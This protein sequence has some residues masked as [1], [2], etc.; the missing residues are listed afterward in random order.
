MTEAINRAAS[1]AST[2]TGNETEV[3]AVMIEA[4]NAFSPTMTPSSGESKT[5]VSVIITEV[6]SKGTTGVCQGNDWIEL[7]NAGTEA[8]DL[9][10]GYVLCDDKGVNDPDAFRF[11]TFAGSSLEPQAYLVLCTKLSSTNIDNAE[12][13]KIPDPSYPQFGI[14]DTDTLSLVKLSDSYLESPSRNSLAYAIL[15]KVGPLPGDENT[16][17]VTYA[18]DAESGAFYYTSTPTPAAANIISPLK[19]KQQLEE[20]R[21][22]ALAAQNQEGAVFFNF[23]NDGLPVKDGMDEMLQL[24]ISMEPEDYEWTSDHSFYEVYRPFQSAKVTDLKGNLIQAFDSPGRIRPKGQSSL[25]MARCLRTGTIPF[26]V[27]MDYTDP[28]Q[29]LFGVQRFYLRTHIADGSYMRDWAY[30]RML[31]RF[32]LPYLRARSVQLIINDKIVGPIYT[33]VE[34]P[35]QE[36]VFA[37]NFP[38]H[39]PDSFA[40]YKITNLGVT[41]GEYSEEQIR[42]ATARLYETN[43]PPYAFERGVHR[44]HVDQLGALQSGQCIDNYYRDVEGYDMEDVVLAWLRHNK[45]CAKM[46]LSEGLVD[47]DLGQSRWDDV[48]ED[49]LDRHLDVIKDRCNQGCT[50]SGLAQ[51]VDVDNFLKTMAFYAVTLNQDSP[52][53]NGN[54][55]YLAQT[56]DGKGWK[57]QA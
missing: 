12:L 33:L 46:R 47:R 39:K 38:D 40:L 7:Y 8:V 57:L 44:R 17:D 20:E 21:R 11:K 16:I 1:N 15:S 25:Y 6:A 22:S 36:Y 2:S 14:G 27:D 32:N 13:V 41:C 28:Y 35:D 48:L 49:F 3:T 30:N 54:N 5:G 29:T 37:R 18:Y 4:A 34:A 42:N 53:G 55:Y 31:A 56:G 24:H 23:G 19:T 9:S 10:N 50:N 45:N 51:D 52:I 43:T 26:Q